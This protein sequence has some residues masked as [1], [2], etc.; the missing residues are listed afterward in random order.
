METKYSL[1]VDGERGVG[2]KRGMRE[3]GIAIR[4]GKKGSE[5]GLEVKMEI[6]GERA[7]LVLAGDLEQESIQGVYKDNS[8]RRGIQKLN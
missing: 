7:S 5:R 8:Y 2:R 3:M 6:T 4:C 1:E